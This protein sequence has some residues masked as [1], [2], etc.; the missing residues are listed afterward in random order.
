MEK[1]TE[2]K[3]KV[4]IIPRPPRASVEEWTPVE[5]NSPVE[6]IEPDAGGLG[7]QTVTGPEAPFGTLAGVTPADAEASAEDAEEEAEEE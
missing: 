4:I 5:P 6:A 1:P 3:G 2:S 7:P